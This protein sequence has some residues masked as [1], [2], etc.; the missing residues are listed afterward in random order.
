M[1]LINDIVC[2]RV[3]TLCKKREYV[4]SNSFQNSHLESYGL[5]ELLKYHQYLK[6]K[7]TKKQINLCEHN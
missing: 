3:I 5:K 2:S 7:D 6:M 1:I 4:S